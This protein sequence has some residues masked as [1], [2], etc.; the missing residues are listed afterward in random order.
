MATARV[1]VWM[2]AGLTTTLGIGHGSL[3]LTTATGSYYITW[4]GQGLSS[5]GDGNRAI[6]FKQI[7]DRHTGNIVA[8]PKAFDLPG[9]AFDYTADCAANKDRM[10]TAGPAQANHRINVTC[11][12]PT[13]YRDGLNMWGLDADEIEQWWRGI[14]NLPPGDPRRNYKAL[15]TKYN[16]N[17]A[18]V[19]AL[20]E[21]G[22]A[23]Y[24]KPP[25]NFVFQGASTLVEWVNKAAARINVLN[26]QAQLIFNELRMKQAGGLNVILDIP[27]LE[28]WKK[29]SNAGP[30]ARRKEQVAEIDR[31]LPL[32]HAAVQ[33]GDRAG[34]LEVL[35]EIQ[36]QV[37]SHLSNKANSDRRDAM[38]MLA[39]KI[40]YV[41]SH[42]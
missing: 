14:M 2:P 35:I 11:K 19:E 5:A 15:S 20:K 3:E 24:A 28:Q 42:W 37:Y 32:Y 38:M 22:L 9:Q 25:V 33:R 40:H 27:T 13:A 4:L 16:C 31:L 17:A 6:G 39:R 23:L 30:L 18:V 34:A 12:S 7:Q 1:N 8:N 36:E 26:M 10:G 21:G 41:I 29:D